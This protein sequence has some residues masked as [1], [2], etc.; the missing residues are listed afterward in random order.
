ML[1]IRRA[2]AH[3]IS[4]LTDILILFHKYFADLDGEQQSVHRAAMTREI[5]DLAFNGRP[6][7]YIYVATENDKIVGA[8]SF[9]RGWTTDT[10]AMYHIPYLFMRPEYHGGRATFALLN[11]VRDIAKKTNVHRLCFSVYGKNLPV[12][13]LYEHIGAKYWAD[14]E[15][16]L[17]MFFDV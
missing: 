9:Y 8:V 7:L 17:F 4:D 10:S 5:R 13:K 12:I 6:L 2:R 16:E 14:A 1:N 15:D 3:D 11:R